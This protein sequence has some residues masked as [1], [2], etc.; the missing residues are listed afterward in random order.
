MR[1]LERS[2]MYII[3]IDGFKVCDAHMHYSGT[4]L[5][6]GMSIIEYMDA[7][8]IDAAVVNTLNTQANL[9]TFMKQDVTSV[10]QQI[11]MPGYEL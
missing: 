1:S 6:R 4:F 5:P 7:N 3:M 2:E 11:K 9:S 10:Q 8:K